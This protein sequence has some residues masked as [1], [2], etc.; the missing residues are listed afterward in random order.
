MWEEKWVMLVDSRF[1][2]IKQGRK[3]GVMTLKHDPKYL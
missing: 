3:A 2:I 1:L